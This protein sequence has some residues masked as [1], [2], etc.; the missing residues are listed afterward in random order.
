V[1]Q[2]KWD[3]RDDDF[4]CVTEFHRKSQNKVIKNDDNF[5]F[6][7]DLGFVI[8]VMLAVIIFGQN[9]QIVILADLA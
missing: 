6:W 2:N 1:I 8:I 9:L 7:P 4:L 3:T 5:K